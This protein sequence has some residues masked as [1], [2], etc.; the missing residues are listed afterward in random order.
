[1]KYRPEIDGLRAIAVITVILFHAGF[2]S[3]SGGFVGVDVF[4]VISGYLITTIILTEMGEGH[5]SLVNFYERRAR[6]ILPPLFL[7]MLLTTIYAWFW[8]LPTDMKEF[9]QSLRAVS[10][11]SS[12]ILFWKTTGYWETASELKPLLHTWSLAVEEQYYFLFPL[13][14]MAMWRYRKRWILFSL[15]G[16]A[17][18]SLTAA[19]WGALNEPVASFYL[20]P[21]RLWELAIGA[22]IAFLFLYKKE[23]VQKMRSSLIVN[24]IMAL[25]GLV[26]ILYAV[27][28]FNES[29]PFPSLYALVPTLGTGMIIFFS[30]AQSRIGRLVGSKPLA[31]IGLISYSA[32]LWHQPLFAFA[33]YQNLANDGDAALLLLSALSLPLAYLSWRYVERPF[34][35]KTS[36][37]RKTVFLFALIGSLSFFT[38]GQAGDYFN[39]FEIRLTEEQKRLMAFDQYPIS[40]IYREETCLLSPEQKPRE[41]S[42]DCFSYETNV[43]LIWGDSHAG[44]LSYGLRESYPAI[45]QL[46]SSGCPPLIGY[47][48]PQRVN[49]QEINNFILDQIE[50][51]KPGRLLLLANWSEPINTLEPGLNEI[52]SETVSLVQQRSPETKIFIIGGFPQWKPSLPKYMLHSHIK[53]NGEAFVYA[54]SINAVRNADD[55]LFEV[56]EKNNVTF[57]SLLE[58]FCIEQKCLSSVKSNDGFEPFAWDHGHLTKSSSILVAQKILNIVNNE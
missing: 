47:N 4:F 41:F 52:L 28:V 35:D 7:I 12:N 32:Y 36:A 1:M 9:S 6:R 2:E 46:T 39:G 58:L 5:F 3:F 22:S 21:T 42:E 55:I 26:M 45:T 8:L 19:Q 43:I 27:I 18:L 20:L 33:R 48:P 50:R 17:A 25:L 49:C 10:S 29:T 40:E 37:N 38:I 11:F 31:S 54:S 51:T 53:L 15:V 13:F 30:S 44:A 23:G 56:A 16:I 14:L 34:R 57:I 24:E